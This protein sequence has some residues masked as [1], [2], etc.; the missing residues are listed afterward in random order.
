LLLPFAS[1]SVALIMFEGGLGLKFHEFREI[2]RVYFRLATLGVT[3]AWIGGT[4][5]AQGLLGLP[6]DLSVLLGATLVVTGPTV[7]LPLLRQVHLR[8][9]LGAV[10]RWEGIGNDPIGAILTVLV[11][12]AVQQKNLL[13][14]QQEILLSV[15]KILL[16]GSLL[17]LVAGWLMRVALERDWIQDSIEG[18]VILGAVVL[19]FLA[20]NGLAEEA[21]LAAVTVAG[22]VLANQDR[23]QVGHIVE[24]GEHLS[25]VLLGVLFLLLSARVR[26]EDLAAMDLRAVLFVLALILVV[27]PLSIYLSTL[28][29]SLSFS[30]RT[31]LAAMAPRGIVAVAII[32]IMTLHLEETGIP[33]AGELVPIVVLVVVSTVAIYSLAAGPLARALGVAQGVPRGALILG[34]NPLG[35][36]LARALRKAKQPVLVADR[37]WRRLAQARM[38]GIPTFFGNILSE[39]AHQHID[40]DG[41]G[42]LLAVT[43]NDEVNSLAGMHLSEIFGRSRV[44]QV[45]PDHAQGP[46]AAQ[47]SREL[48]SHY[49][50]DEE[51]DLHTLKSRLRRGDQLQTTTLSEEFSEE[52]H[53]EQIGEGSLLLFRIRPGEPLEVFTEQVL[54][55]TEAGDILVSL[56]ARHGPLRQEEPKATA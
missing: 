41:L 31:F 33:R 47:T 22:M 5:A 49:L 27:R 18:S 45:T 23:V 38:E 54:P 9:P 3:L 1:L 12:E 56:V 34:A 2:G 50:F 16:L 29:T 40:F 51:E 53:L 6:F 39:A 20:G 26:A 28:G 17:G 36:E 37:N 11:L 15:S 24:F 30:E 52:Q 46:E 42:C 13:H 19:T 48:R 25:A 44:Y 10:L 7:I 21:G 32:S 14:A 4:L 43:A 35:M 8:P 55:E